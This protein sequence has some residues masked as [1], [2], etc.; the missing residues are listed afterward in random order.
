MRLVLRRFRLAVVVVAV[1]L[2]TAV[3]MSAQLLHRPGPSDDDSCSSGVVQHDAAA[4]SI[5]AA[6]APDRASHCA[7]CHWWLSGG[8]FTAFSLPAPQAPH[9]YVGRVV[10]TPVAALQLV[11]AASRPARAPPVA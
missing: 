2:L 1:A 9:I 10:K 6:T 7:I 4:H 3:P 5:R 8:R 11:A